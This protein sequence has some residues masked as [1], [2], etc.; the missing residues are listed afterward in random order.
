MADATEAYGEFQPTPSSRRATSRQIS[1][2]CL[3]RSFNPRPPRGGRPH[4]RNLS[5]VTRLHRLYENSFNPRPPR[6]GRLRGLVRSHPYLPV[7]TH[8]LLAEG[9]AISV[10][11]WR[12]SIWVSTH[13]LLAEGDLFQVGYNNGWGMFQPTP[14]SRRAT[15]RLTVLRP[16]S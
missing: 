6:G 12:S 15:R 10:A 2:S 14:S 13:A 9:D 7:S 5:A 1:S 4:G 16:C 11:G 8:A 3:R